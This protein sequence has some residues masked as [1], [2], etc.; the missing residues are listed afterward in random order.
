MYVM[1]ESKKK[2]RG[3]GINKQ[4]RPLNP[5]RSIHS[6]LRWLAVQELWEDLV[7]EL[8]LPSII[9]PPNGLKI[10]LRLPPTKVKPCKHLKKRL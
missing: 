10:H 6:L 2:S 7:G 3:Y 1:R 9:P 8:S 4:T 5:R